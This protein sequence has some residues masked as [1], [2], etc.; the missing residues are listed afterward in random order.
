MTEVSTSSSMASVQTIEVPSDW[1]NKSGRLVAKFTKENS[2]SFQSRFVSKK[3]LNVDLLLDS[4]V[5][6]T[7]L[8]IF[9]TFAN[10]QITLLRYMLKSL[11]CLFTD[12]NYW[13]FREVWEK[14]WSRK[15]FWTSFRDTVHVVMDRCVTTCEKV[16]A[17]VPL[18]ASLRTITAK[19]IRSG[20]RASFRNLSRSVLENDARLARRPI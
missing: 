17:T 4:R 12:K 14:W 10:F 15:T 3:I 18:V 19:Y 16:V 13:K 7:K 1:L 2:P 6:W 5:V 20:P 8:W 9:D 11:Q